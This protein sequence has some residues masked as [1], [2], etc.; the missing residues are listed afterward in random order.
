M[1]YKSALFIVLAFGMVSCQ[2]DKNPVATE[3]FRIQEPKI[4]L[5]KTNEQK[6]FGG[7]SQKARPDLS[8]VDE[9]QFHEAEGSF[10]I[11]YTI[12]IRQGL[13]CH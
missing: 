1:N 3:S 8:L 4:I 9:I 11:L 10:N 5:K 12:D 6:D 13:G 2:S 7:F